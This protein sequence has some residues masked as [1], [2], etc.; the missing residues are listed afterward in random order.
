MVRSTTG[1]SLSLSTVTCSRSIHLLCLGARELQEMLPTTQAVHSRSSV[2][3]TNRSHCFFYHSNGLC[4]SPVHLPGFASTG[5]GGEKLHLI[6][7]AGFFNLISWKVYFS[8]T[9]EQLEGG[10]A[11]IPCLVWASVSASAHRCLHHMHAF[12]WMKDLPF[13]CLV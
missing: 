10:I 9:I 13:L 3:T 7:H 6:Q 4:T 1:A 5:G 8:S 12:C 11:F 2:G